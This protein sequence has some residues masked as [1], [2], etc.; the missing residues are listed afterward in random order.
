MFDDQAKEL[1]QLVRL[2]ASPPR[3]PRPAPKLI[4]VTAGKGGVGATTVA[5]NLAMALSQPSPWC[6][7]ADPAPSTAGVLLVDANPAGADVANRLDMQAEHGVSQVL[8]GWRG[9]RET[10]LPGPRG[11]RILPSHWAEEQLEAW[12]AAGQQRLLDDLGALAG[13]ID[14]VVLDVGRSPHLGS[15]LFWSAAD[16][17]VVV[18]TVDVPSV[19][20]AYA[21]IKLCC[22][23]RSPAQVWTFFNQCS[24]ATLASDAHTRLAVACQRFL[25]LQVHAGGYWEHVPPTMGPD[26]APWSLMERSA[27]AAASLATFARRLSLAELRTTL[28]AHQRTTA[29]WHEATRLAMATATQANATSVRR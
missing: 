1:R 8:S 6:A 2:D 27:A 21:A 18:S 7:D 20:E 19:M 29:A 4:L 26:E 9:V 11:I 12:S 25:A 16:A 24:Q 23:D 28:G 15:K 14:Y 17:A 13:E 10:W 5:I 3:Q 22:S